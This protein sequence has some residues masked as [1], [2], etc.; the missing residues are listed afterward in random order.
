MCSFCIIQ[1]EAFSQ[2]KFPG[3]TV[4]TATDLENYLTFLSSP[5]LKGRANGEPGLEIAEQYIVSQAKTIGLKP[6]NGGSY[7]QSYTVMKN[8]MDPEKTSIKIS[9]STGDSVVIR[10]PIFQLLP[11]G[12]TNYTVEG[13]VVFAGYGLKQDK[14]GYD[15]FKGI[16][17]DGKI[18]IVMS[19]APTSEDGKRYL[20][21]GKWDSYM[22]LQTKLTAIMFSKAK[23][24]L[25]VM[26]PKSGFQ[27]IDNQFPGIGGQLNATTRLK[28]TQATPFQFPNMTKILFVDR[29]VADELL[30][31][32]PSLEEL[33]KKIDSDLKPNSFVIPGKR[34]KITEVVK[35][36]EV[37][38]YNVAATIE[39]SD[40]VLKNEYVAFSGHMDH[41]GEGSGGVNAGAD[42]DASGCA[43]LLSMAKA[44]Q[45]L[46]KKPARSLLFLWVS[47]EEV[48]LF[49]SQTYVN[50]PLVPL[51]KTV[52]D[53]NMD[54]IG[55]IKNPA[56]SVSETPVSGPTGAFVISDNQSKDL[57]AIAAEADRNS[58]LDFDYSLSGTTNPQQLYR[59]SD[60]FNFV[61]K[62]IP[63]LFF[64]TGIHA[65]YHTPRDVVDKI[66]FEKLELVTR[67][68]Y[69]IGYTIAMR[70]ERV[71][72][73]N[74]YSKWQQK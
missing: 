16:Q 61:K 31:G 17:A 43:A 28:G 51:D 14:A 69:Q 33:Q 54:M 21:E 12:P 25:I 63:T 35:S 55:R 34:L 72:V 8:T 50:N 1:N 22:G 68:V 52:A 32:N 19:G 56:D 49:G 3:T 40:P 66:N 11:T 57:M 2:K 60:H 45:S 24:A 71:V 44:F 27:T 73:D 20:I 39:G 53:L 18:L 9:G 42:D 59:R 23:A 67:T 5:L 10:K 7:L 64:T 36:D 15:D 58:T 13:E 38:M 46:E 26:D 74:P 30:K 70:K 41:I 4:I 65:D 48:G 6:A 47:G 29:S 62:D 37:T